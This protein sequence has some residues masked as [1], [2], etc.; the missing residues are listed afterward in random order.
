[1]W[2]NREYFEERARRIDLQDAEILRLRVLNA[3]LSTENSK[4]LTQ[5]VRDNLHIDWL[6]HR[7]NALEKQNA[8]LMQ[9]AAG[10]A[11]PVPE[12]VSTAPGTPID[13]Q[14]M[15]SFEDVGDE[16]AARL[17]IAHTPDGTLAFTQ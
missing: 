11:M 8:V 13:F 2:I 17:G 9:K 6:R 14:T 16:E 1:M 3:S 15:P 12:I 7:V 4:C 5:Q 10:I